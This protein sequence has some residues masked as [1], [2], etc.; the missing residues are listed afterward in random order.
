MKEDTM[1]RLLLVCA[2]IVAHATARSAGDWR[3]EGFTLRSSDL[4]IAC[5]VS[6]SA[7]NSPVAEAVRSACDS[8]AYRPA[9]FQLGSRWNS[10]A[11]RFLRSTLS[12]VASIDDSISRR[13]SGRVNR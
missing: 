2:L 1:A 10:V 8:L 3:D 12:Q 13:I 11:I 4:T 6:L 7:W 9:W 5:A